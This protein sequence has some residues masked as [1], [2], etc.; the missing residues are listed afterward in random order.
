[1]LYSVRL[2]AARVIAKALACQSCLEEGIIWDR[3]CRRSRCK[4]VDSLARTLI[5]ELARASDL[6]GI[7]TA[8][9]NINHRM[10]DA[11]NEARL[12]SQEE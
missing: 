6:I 1:M 2:K 3:Q 9:V 12:R 11:Q 10:S 5:P 4:Y 7:A 8:A